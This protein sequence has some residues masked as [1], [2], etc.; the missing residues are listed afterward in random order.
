[1]LCLTASNF[2][3]MA[4]ICLTASTFELMVIPMSKL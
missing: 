1:M 2:A 3:L 4:L